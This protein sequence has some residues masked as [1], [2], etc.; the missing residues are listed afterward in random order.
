MPDVPAKPAVSAA[1]AS[2]QAM[3]STAD[4]PA[5]STR[6]S[7]HDPQQIGPYRIIE[8]IGEGGMGIIYK[9]EQRH[10]VRR[11]V[12]LKVIKLGMDTRQV[13]PRL[14]FIARG[15]LGAADYLNTSDYLVC[16]I[17]RREAEAMFGL[18]PETRPTAGPASH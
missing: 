11:V 5:K 9:A 12:A 2:T 18:R 8:N 4:L 17:L 13:I 10:P 6:L 16:Q 3:N 1:T 15:G 7:P 14:A